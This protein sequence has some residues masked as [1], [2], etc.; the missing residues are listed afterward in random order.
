VQIGS[1][2]TYRSIPLQS[3]YCAAKHA[4]VGFSD[5]LRSELIHDKSNVAL[6]VVQL[7]GVNTPQFDWAQ[8]DGDAVGVTK[9]PAKAVEL[10]QSLSSREHE[11]GS[12]GDQR[13][14]EGMEIPTNL[15]PFVSGDGQGTF[16]GRVDLDRVLLSRFLDVDFDEDAITCG[17]G[18][19]LQRVLGDI[20]LRLLSIICCAAA[21]PLNRCRSSMSRL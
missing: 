21:T 2:L 12:A 14:E 10:N 3:A 18:D 20:P 8:Q 16:V 5:S 11:P 7:P 17:V 6:A 1:A 13:G 9:G 15:F 19:E 4:I